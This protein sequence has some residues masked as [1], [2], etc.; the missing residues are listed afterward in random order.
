MG[1]LARETGR[2]GRQGVGAPSARHSRDAGRH[3]EAPGK[4]LT[5]CRQQLTVNPNSKK[6]SVLTRL[7]LSRGPFLRGPPSFPGPE[8]SFVRTSGI[9]WGL[10]LWW[11]VGVSVECRVARCSDA[12]PAVL[13]GASRMLFGSQSAVDLRRLV[14]VDIQSPFRRGANW[15]G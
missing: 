4:G 11:V 10:V 14:V 7:M 2:G 3:H 6:L 15:L 13:L 5:F 12:T 1:Q 9:V 8:M